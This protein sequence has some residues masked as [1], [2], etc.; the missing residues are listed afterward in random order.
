MKCYLIYQTLLVSATCFSAHCQ[1]EKS[2]SKI[3]NVQDD[4][5]KVWLKDTV[6]TVQKSERQTEGSFKKIEFVVA[7]DS[8]FFELKKTYQF[9]S[10]QKVDKKEVSD[11]LSL[12]KDYGEL[13]TGSYSLSFITNQSFYPSSFKTLKYDFVNEIK[14]IKII[15]G[16]VISEYKYIRGRLSGKKVTRK[17]ASEI[18]AVIYEFDWKNDKLVKRKIE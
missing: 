4:V 18:R 6:A 16:D 9:Q 17:S 1:S 13:P 10:I 3:S 2:N 12:L 7:P 8:L 15:E 11:I 5:F 14:K